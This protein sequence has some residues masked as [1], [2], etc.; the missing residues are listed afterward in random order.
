MTA[1]AQTSPVNELLEELTAQ[2]QAVTLATYQDFLHT[3]A[4]LSVDGTLDPIQRESIIKSLVGNGHNLGGKRL[5]TN[6]L[7]CF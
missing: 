3:V 4:L 6:A 1:T 2:A 7:C 5:I